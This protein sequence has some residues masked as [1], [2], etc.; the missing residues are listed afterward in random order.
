[1][2]GRGKPATSMQKTYDDCYLTCSTAV[3]FE[4]QNNE[5]EALRSWR[6]AL[7]QIYYHNAYRM[8]TGWRPRSETE[9]A[10]QESLRQMELQCKERVDLLEALR[11]SREEA[12]ESETQAKATASSTSIPLQEGADQSNSGGIGGGSIPP[13]GYSDISRPTP[14]PPLPT[15]NKRPSYTSK[16]SS[17]TDVPT[18][19]RSPL[20]SSSAFASSSSMLAPQSSTGQRKGSRTPSPEKRGGMLRTL[21]AGGKE[22]TS[23]GKLS[24]ATF[25]KPAA[26]SKAATQAWSI[27]QRNASV[28]SLEQAN[29]N[30]DGPSS[31]ATVWDPYTRTLVDPSNSSR[32]NMPT[33]T[34]SA[35]PAAQQ[36][37]TARSSQEQPRPPPKHIQPPSPPDYFV[38]YSAS[39]GSQADSQ[40]PPYPDHSLLNPVQP[41]Q[42]YASSSEHLGPPS[43]I[44]SPRQ[45]PNPT[46]TA[47]TTKARKQSPV[48][49]LEPVSLP[50]YR[51]EY[52]PVQPSKYKNP[53]NA[54]PPKTLKDLENQVSSSAPAATSQTKPKVAPPIP[55]KA[56]GVV[57]AAKARQQ[58][59]DR[60]VSSG[61]SADEHSSGR[62]NPTRVRRKKNTTAEENAPAPIVESVT[63]N[64]E[65]TTAEP[66]NELSEWDERV[67]NL[68]ANL[69]RGVDEAA[70]KQIFN[71]IVIQGDEVH[72]DDVAGLEIAKSALKETVV[73]PF[74]RPDLFMGLR[75]PARGMLLFGPP[76]TGKTMLARAVATESKSTFFAISAS[77]L[78]SKY[79]GESEK[80]VRALFAIAKA[81]APSIIFV[82]EIDSLLSARGGS[83]EHEAT[84][85]IKTEFLI[86]WSDLA[87]A[88][89]GKE[90]SDKD[91]ERGD[92]SRVLVLA[93]TNLPWAIDEAARRRFVRR[94]YIPLP[95]D[96]VRKLQLTTL[97]AAQKHNI[98]DEDLNELVYLTEGFSGSDITALAKDA[99]MGPL[100]SL[101][102]K[103]LH[104]SPDD[105][106]PID[107]TDFKASLINIRPSVSASGLKEFED[108]AKEFVTTKPPTN[109]STPGA[110]CCQVYAPAAQLNWWYT[111]GTIEAVQQTIITEYLRYNNTVVPTATVTITNSSAASVTRTY[112]IQAGGNAP[113]FSGIPTGMNAPFQG[114]QQYDQTVVLTG[115][116]VDYGYTSVTAPTPFI[117][118][119]YVYVFPGTLNNAGTCM[120]SPTVT[121]STSTSDM[122]YEVSSA[123]MDWFGIA[124]FEPLGT[125]SNA[126]QYT[127]FL[128]STPYISVVSTRPGEW[129]TDAKATKLNDDLITYLAQNQVALSAFPE[130]RSCTA[131]SGAGA[132]NVHIRVSLLTTSSAVTSTTNAMF[133]NKVTTTSAVPASQPPPAGPISTPS[134]TQTAETQQTPSEQSSGQTDQPSR[135]IT[136]QT[137][138][139]PSDIPTAATQE[140][141]SPSQ[142]P[143]DS[144]TTSETSLNEPH[145]QPTLASDASNQPGVQKT[146]ADSPAV[147]T[148]QSDRPASA[149]DQPSADPYQITSAGDQASNLPEPKPTN[150]Q[151]VTQEIPGAKTAQNTAAATDTSPAETSHAPLPV[152]I[153]GVTVSQVS[154]GYIVGSQTL[155]F[156]G[157]A[158]EISGTTYS[159]Q[160]SSV[161]AAVNGQNVQVTTIG[162]PVETTALVVLGGATARPVT[163]GAYIVADQTLSRGG[164]GIEI[165]GTTYSLE[166]SGDNV[167]V[168][169]E[170]TPVSSLQLALAQPATV[171]VGDVTPA[172][173]SSGAYYIV[174]GQTLS[175]GASAIEISSVTYS[176]PRSGANI[177][178]NGATSLANAASTPAPVVLG[179]V[180]AASFIG[181]GYFVSSQI[182][183]PGG[184]EIEVSGTTYSLATSGN[185]VFVNG[186]PTAIPI[187]ASAVPL[188]G[189][190]S[191]VNAV[192]TPMPV[193]FGSVTAAPFISGGYVLASQVLSPG[194]TAIELSGT[195]YSLAA[196]GNTV[197]IDGKPTDFQN[198]AAAVSLTI[199]SQTFTAVAASITPLVI[200]SQTLTPGGPTITVSGTTY[201]LPPFV[202]D[203]IVVNGQTKSLAQTS[204]IAVLSANPEQL[205]FT[206]LESGVMIA[207]QTLYPGEAITVNGETLSLASSG[208]VVVVKSGESTTTEGL[209][210]YIWQGIAT[211][212]SASTTDPTSHST[213]A[214]GLTKT[215]ASE[216]LLGSTIR[217]ET[218]GTKTEGGATVAMTTASR[219]N[220]N[221]LGI[222]SCV[223]ACLVIALLVGW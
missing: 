1:M 78:T 29:G 4:G 122:H 55:R 98:S 63:E 27:T 101:G 107:V 177:V 167:I 38:Q 169:G 120:G 145:G 91:K 59:D 222:P 134:T 127:T 35:P 154:N 214:S 22:R 36:S 215:D 47:N 89:A 178:V 133:A 2:L 46:F 103:L 181:G 31:S 192:D 117:G 132:P 165:S 121:E 17:G 25:R 61:Y 49:R 6:N 43:P 18:V 23:S 83:S 116:E 30:L 130:I 190:S 166:P 142:G 21:R 179:S 174:A 110:F 168:N 211:P 96:W 219:S 161:T 158:I 81:L 73:Y 148:Q 172:P 71:E 79:L 131:V 210:D 11:Q 85:R 146:T 194:S 176:L 53:P 68:L 209:G 69:P 24:N 90:T 92:A 3:Y 196:S 151:D 94:Q 8:P 159:L 157:S 218:A 183:S 82:D 205:S 33:H 70:A 93:A 84:R 150:P 188:T 164:P 160:A 105:I 87:K 56:V 184:S 217:S 40:R 221:N 14:P 137:G 100:R 62:E 193:A 163:S 66:Q 216:S 60:N 197:F 198:V 203:G 12:A 153:G 156:G 76:G 206:P 58:L 195:T 48:R 19:R 64:S 114:G 54:R 204:G 106:R 191:L 143:N 126:V 15:R 26:A 65:A 111:N 147:P 115:T 129:Y 13:V 200:A 28:G 16:H 88:A 7:D 45:R 112:N 67:K 10:L 52:L 75:E 109:P 136:D 97:M 113:V 175:P 213:E 118:F 173:E 44:T 201:S 171:V 144:P 42:A 9:K 186:K 37:T 5:A 74:L 125:I 39:D 185:T 199:G 152:A 34:A 135:H 182:L 102:E 99:A 212:T 32:P 141:E 149:G 104:M 80:L 208:S 139:S 108:W 202:T 223:V 187:A 155:A 72:W 50:S 124:A 51:N 41:S 57:S 207:S 86:Q 77:S 189:A 20:Q 170:A 123:A 95:E 128:L 140:P 162:S 138:P 119:G 220:G 180:T